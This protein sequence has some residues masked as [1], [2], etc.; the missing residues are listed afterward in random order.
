[1]FAWMTKDQLSFIFDMTNKH[2][3]AW[4]EKKYPSIS[5]KEK[6]L[7]A[8]ELKILSYASAQ[9]LFSLDALTW[10]NKTP[11]KLLEKLIGELHTFVENNQVSE[12]YLKDTA[13]WFSFWAR[14]AA[15]SPRVVKDH[16]AYLDSMRKNECTENLFHRNG[17]MIESNKE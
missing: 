8:N 3:D 11:S 10:K 1:V 4:V 15:D 5:S 6:K 9:K 17:P 16:D 2:A 13:K 7:K 14:A 12:M